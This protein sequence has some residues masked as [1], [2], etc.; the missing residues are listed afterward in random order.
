MTT[1]PKNK[2]NGAAWEIKLTRYLRD[3][4]INCERL[5]LSGTRDEGDIAISDPRI[6]F[7][8]VIE[9]KAPGPGQ[10]I[11][12]S[13]WVRESVEEASHYAQ[14]RNLKDSPLPIVVIKA[15]GKTTD[16]AYVVMRLSD[17]LEEN[18]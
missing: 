1:G 3:K 14:A 12:L 13:E 9:A 17:F 7:P 4:G 8:I 5:R 6:P 11:R 10:P 15:P 2:R 16:Q 18:R